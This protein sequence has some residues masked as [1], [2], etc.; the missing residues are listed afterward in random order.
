MKLIRLFTFYLYDK[1]YPLI[2][3]KKATDKIIFKKK[4]GFNKEIN[5]KLNLSASDW[6]QLFL[7][8][9]IK[10]TDTVF[11][12]TTFSCA[13]SFEGGA[14]AFV[15]FLKEYFGKE[16]NIVLS[17]YTFD[18]SPLMY[19][20]ENPIFDVNK[21][22]GRLSL[23]NEIF[24]TSRGV[25][26]SI[27]PTHSL[28]AFGK[29]A[30]YIVQDHEINKFCY[31]DASPF[32]KLYELDAKEI[33]IGVRPASISFH[34]IEQFSNSYKYLFK[35]LSYPIMC[36]LKINNKI[37]FK[38]F[39]VVDSFRNLEDNYKVF[40]DT[41]VEPSKFSMDEIDLYV[42]NFKTGLRGLKMLM[43]SNIHWHNVGSIWKDLFMRFI[44]KN[45]V[46]KIFFD[47]K[48]DTLYPIKRENK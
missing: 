4:L 7:E 9:N 34:Y 2:R 45:I 1:F 6:R 24:R 17:S 32:T 29:N 30:A 44:L 26:R 36:R 41:E 27:H 21:S 15:D 12:R 33:S 20:S 48:K 8:A 10:K 39:Q 23:F 46:L 28:C 16:G 25:L 18:K 11:L 35:E 22:P 31:H 43:K 40:K 19:L 3:K 47:N 38:E 13:N 42:L 5:Q 37:V 14:I